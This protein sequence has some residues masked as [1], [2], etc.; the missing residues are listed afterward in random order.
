[1]YMK[2]YA[3]DKWAVIPDTRVDEFFNMVG[4]WEPLIVSTE[5]EFDYLWAMQ[6]MI[7]KEFKLLL[8]GRDA[9]IPNM[10]PTFVKIDIPL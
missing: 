6:I 2:Q 10:P 8:D 4:V 5:A 3:N 9:P 1:M 7:G